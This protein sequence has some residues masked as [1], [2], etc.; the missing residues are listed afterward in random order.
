MVDL[1]QKQKIKA[2]NKAKGKDVDNVEEGPYQT[3]K[4]GGKETPETPQTDEKFF[5]K[6]AAE[7]GGKAKKT[8][9]ADEKSSGDSDP[10]KKGGAVLK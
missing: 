8:V 2:A 5:K 9:S 6:T 3:A 1:N 7:E 4:K 10:Q